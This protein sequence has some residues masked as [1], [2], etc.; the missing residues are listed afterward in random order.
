MTEAFHEE[1]HGVLVSLEEDTSS[2]YLY[3]IWFPYTKTNITKIK[4]GSFIA[5]KNFAGL[6]LNPKYSVLEIVS[7]LPVHY[8][9]G[10]TASATEKA[11]PGFVVEAAKAARQDWEQEEPLEQTTKI[12]SSA[13]STGLQLV[14]TGSQFSVGSDESMPM[15][16]EDVFLLTNDATMNIVNKNLLLGTVPYIQPCW[17]VLNKEIVVHIS[18]E[19]LLRTHFGVFGFTGSGKSNLNSTIIN[20]L[21]KTKGL[22][23][24]LFDLM[25]EYTGLLIDLLVKSKN[26]FILSL[27]PDSL[28]GGE[29]LEN[30]LRGKG[31]E[32]KAIENV[33][34]TL[35]LPKELAQCRSFYKKCVKSLIDQ[36]KFKVLTSGS[37]LTYEILYEEISE[38]VPG[39]LGSAKNAV[40]SWLSIIQSHGDSLAS[41]D[42]IRALVHQIDDFVSHGIPE[43]FSSQSSAS[44]GSG[45]FLQSSDSSSQQLVPRGSSTRINLPQTARSYFL[46][47]KD[48][49]SKHIVR[50]EGSPINRE[51]AISI[52][53]LIRTLNDE[54]SALVII[55]SGR[56]D[57]LRQFSSQ[58][59]TSL[60]NDRKRRGANGP[61]VL[62][63]YDEADEF[64]PS[65][66]TNLGPSYAA[67]KAAINMLARRGRKFGLGLSFATQ[68]V[69]Y[70]DTSILAQAHTYLISKLPRQYDREAV[71]NAFGLSEDMLRRTLKFSKGQWLLVS[72]EATGLENVPLPVQFPNANKR[73][74]EFLEHCNFPSETQTLGQ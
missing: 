65:T 50:A 43:T 30:V 54:D 13:I 11:Y 74:A 37:A 9:L 70:L 7:T 4:E 38:D 29:S 27:E 46:G 3:N 28:P 8:A 40:A 64:M 73:I 24:V 23:I 61:Q 51:C 52:M 15:V 2:G 6:G 12:R 17:L 31:D 60:F 58:L 35:L 34:A 36:K 68:R 19:D 48:K 20:E 66:N 59:V 18:T 22:K 44:S 47:A 67:S 42:Y 39:T 55:Q 32:Q 10:S 45:L 26:A 56:D 14:F 16:G 49:L 57:S 21:T 69:A 33:V 25:L 71:S 63:L 53:D 41:Q 72:Y 5:I 1:P 62:F